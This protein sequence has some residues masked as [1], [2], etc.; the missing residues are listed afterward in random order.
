MRP[1]LVISLLGLCFSEVE[2]WAQLDRSHIV[3]S[4]FVLS[5]DYRALGFNP[6]LMT[7]EGWNGGHRKTRGGLE[8][9]L[10]IKS[11]FL[12]N[13]EVW[14]QF[15]GTSSEDVG[16]WTAA[17]WSAALAEEQ[18]EISGAFLTAAF[19]HKLGTWAVSYANRRGSQ[20]E[21][22]LGERTAKLFADGGLDLYS[23]IQLVESGEV[24]SV[25]DY[26]FS[27]GDAWTGLTLAGEE[28]L[29][30]LLDGTRL[31]YQSVR[32]HD[33][34]IS[35]SWNGIGDWQLHTGI[36]GRLLLG[37]SYFELEGGDG[38]VT[39]FAAKSGGLAW[40]QLQALHGM[41]SSG[42]TFD[43]VDLL[44][45]A[46]K[47]WGMDVGATLAHDNRAWVSASLV[48][49]GWMEW[50]GATY[51]VN[52]LHVGT[53]NW[54]SSDA[55]VDPDQWVSGALQS[56]SPDAWFTAGDTVIRRVANRPLFS[57]GGAWMPARAIVFAG[58]AT[59]RNREA[60]AMGGASGG[61]ALG[62][63]LTQALTAEL[64]VQR[65]SNDAMRIPASL[66]LSMSRGWQTGVRVGDISAFW[67]GSQPEV[68]A[69]FCFLR[70]Q[71]SER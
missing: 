66:R 18:L 12:N 26:D 60:L 56:L 20:A 3:S 27:L 41:L 32:S 37:S 42:W 36:G 63:R 5:S 24:V 44:N 46:G 25:A 19:S 52:D 7:L 35:K 14:R 6:S 28:T 53:S 62:V 70:Y 50:E 1:F 30:N 34:G 69:Q 49:V 16:R 2:A 15:F 47:G 33:V 40:N 39:A 21:I 48:D 31:R 13:D 54:G 67:K 9:G 43:V 4:P 51:D 45:P 55:A 17:E 71:F 38:E 57:L 59:I 23:D 29:A 22:E 68:A 58:H 65:M 10:S 64:G 8:G 61:L 11:D